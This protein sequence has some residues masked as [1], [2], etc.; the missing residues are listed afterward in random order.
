MAYP[1]YQHEV[2]ELA[3]TS[4]QRPIIFLSNSSPQTFDLN[5]NALTWHWSKA[6]Y[7]VQTLG[8]A[9]P[10]VAPRMPAQTGTVLTSSVILFPHLC[11]HQKVHPILQDTSQMPPTSSM[12][13]SSKP[14]G[15]DTLSLLLEPQE[16]AI[17]TCAGHLPW[18]AMHP[19]TC[20]PLLVLLIRLSFS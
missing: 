1:S 7:S 8:P 6:F 10:T 4:T 18:P 19:I 5:I 15:Q 11:A 12:R 14:L 9:D 2:T 16:H 13:M 3:L 17:S 20:G